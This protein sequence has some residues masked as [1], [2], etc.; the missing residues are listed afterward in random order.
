MATTMTEQE[1]LAA[2]DLAHLRAALTALREIVPSATSP[3]PAGDF[4]LC[5]RA[6]S[7]WEQDIR[8]QLRVE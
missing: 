3:I 6:L 4:A 5:L 8:A 2:M 7:L 1:Y